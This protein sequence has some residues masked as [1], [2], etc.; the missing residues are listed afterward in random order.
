[1]LRAVVVSEVSPAA[2]A[3]GGWYDDPWGQARLRWW[4][5][6]QWTHHVS[7]AF[8]AWHAGSGEAR[9]LRDAEHG[10][11]RWLR[12]VVLL[13]PVAVG[14]VAA[15]YGAAFHFVLDH[16]D[17]STTPPLPGWVQWVNVAT[18]ITIAILVMRIIWLLRAART[19]EALRLPA[20][21]SPGWAAAGW[22]IPVLNLW[23]PYQ[24]VRDLFPEAER[25][26]ARLG[27]WW[28]CTLGSTIAVVMAAIAVALPLPALVA[29]FA[30]GMVP[31]VVASVLE[32]RLVADAIACHTRLT[33]G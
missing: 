1:V 32:R 14:I 19:A 21:R 8:D 7:T 26:R 29:V 11:G 12:L 33:G 28:G 9:D 23:W 31:V 6:S 18:P 30:V 13:Q 5:G 25:P 17:E 10:P 20:K 24:G 27:W 16:I 4:D 22:V 15:V 3:P 2:G